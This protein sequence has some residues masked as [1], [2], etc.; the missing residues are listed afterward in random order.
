MGMISDVR[1]ERTQAQDYYNKA[2]N[3]DG[4]EGAAQTEAKMYLKTPYINPRKP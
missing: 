4:G 2:L 3:V 1:K